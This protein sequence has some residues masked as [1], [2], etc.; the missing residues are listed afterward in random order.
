MTVTEGRW[1]HSRTSWGRSDDGR[2]PMPTGILTPE[3]PTDPTLHLST[4]MTLMLGWGC[5][6]TGTSGVRRRLSRS[7]WGRRVSSALA[8]SPPA[9]GRGSTSSSSR[10]IYSSLVAVLGLPITGCQNCCTVPGTQPSGSRAVVTTSQFVKPGWRCLGNRV[11]I[12]CGHTDTGLGRPLIRR[13]AHPVPHG[14]ARDTRTAASPGCRIETSRGV[15]QACRFDHAFDEFVVHPTH[16]LPVLLGQGME[17][18]VGESH[19]P[20]HHLWFVTMLR[21]ELGN[22][23]NRWRRPLF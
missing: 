20:I 18:A 21:E 3:A 14:S 12:Q 9:T 23:L 19:L 22:L 2:L 5:T 1:R 17:G 4:G 16:Q 10:E 15:G 7:A 13:S 6:P 11:W 8:I